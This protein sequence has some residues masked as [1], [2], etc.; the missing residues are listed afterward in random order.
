MINPGGKSSDKNYLEFSHSAMAT[1]F[2]IFISSSDEEYSSQAA[3]EVFREID[4]LESELSRFLPNSDV[5]RI[6]SMR[7]GEKIVLGED[8]FNC[9]SECK[10]IFHATKSTFN[11]LIGRQGE[12][13]HVPGF[14]DIVIDQTELS[15]QLINEGIQVDLGGYGKGYAV[16]KAA[17]MLLEWGVGPAM[18]SAGQSSVR[19]ISGKEPFEGWKISITNPFVDGSA[20]K[21]LSINDLSIGSSGLS[22]GN[23]IIDSRAKEYLKNERAVWVFGSG[24]AGLLDALSTSFMVLDISEIEEVVEHYDVMGTLI[25]EKKEGSPKETIIGRPPINLSL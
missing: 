25:Y 12:I 17:H 5:S 16:D 1:V 11:I 15:L 19:A 20:G 4:R 22:K 10:K 18:I 24:A 9:I 6:N 21:V 2:R 23:H 14:E 13:N 3:W 7:E 8:A